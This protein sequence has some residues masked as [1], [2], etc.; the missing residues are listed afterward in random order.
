VCQRHQELSS[1]SDYPIVLQCNLTD[2]PQG[3]LP[4][5]KAVV[6]VALDRTVEHEAESGQRSEQY[7]QDQSETQAPSEL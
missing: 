1:Q 3:I 6:F 2:Y 7:Q 4:R 5:L